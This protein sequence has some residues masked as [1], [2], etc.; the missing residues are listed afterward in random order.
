MATLPK[1]GPEQAGRSLTVGKR[2]PALKQRLVNPQAD[3]VC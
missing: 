2:Q 3:G 1:P